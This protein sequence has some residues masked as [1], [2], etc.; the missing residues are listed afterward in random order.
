VIA[1][2][3]G[4]VRAAGEDMTC[5]ATARGAQWRNGISSGAAG[6]DE[7]PRRLH[8]IVQAIEHTCRRLIAET[9]SDLKPGRRWLGL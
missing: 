6:H 7:T 1:A 2:A 5:G 8:Q 9:R 3:D 4:L